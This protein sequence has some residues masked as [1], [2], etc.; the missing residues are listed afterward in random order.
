MEEE[1][2]GGGGGSSVLR[3]RERVVVPGCTRSQ[4]ECLAQAE[5]MLASLKQCLARRPDRK[6]LVT[7]MLGHSVTNT[8]TRAHRD[9]HT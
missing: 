8:N 4:R 6:I 2:G 5:L 9:T 3:Q 1:K 7:W